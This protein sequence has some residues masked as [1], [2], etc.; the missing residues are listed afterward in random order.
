[1]HLIQPALTGHTARYLR[2]YLHHQTTASITS[3]TPSFE[4]QTTASI[5]PFIP[6]F[7]R[8]ERTD[9]CPYFVKGASYIVY[10]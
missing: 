10:F 5:A 9:L 8:Q 7:E 3:F 6:A 4:R 2:G 1:M